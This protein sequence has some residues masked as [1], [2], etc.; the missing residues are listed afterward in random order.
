MI[1]SSGWCES[2]SKTNTPPIQSISKNLSEIS[3]SLS[4]P[5]LNLQGFFDD[6]V[7]TITPGKTPEGASVRFKID[8]S[9]LRI[10]SSSPEQAILVSSLLASVPNPIVEFQSTAIAKIKESLFKVTG[11]LWAFNKE[12]EVSF[13]V[14][15]VSHSK[16]KTHIKGNIS[17]TGNLPNLAAAASGEARFNLVFLTR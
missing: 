6:Y 1:A 2:T 9:G 8:L 15:V 11:R 10:S 14:T 17:S 3:F 5:A 16:G 4:S 7:G 12:R 13:P